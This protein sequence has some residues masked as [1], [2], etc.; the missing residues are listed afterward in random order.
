MGSAA[1]SSEIAEQLE[2]IDS[3]CTT[4][5]RHGIDYWLFGGRAV[6]FGSGRS[7]RAHD[8]IDIAAWRVDYDAIIASLLEAGWHHTPVPDE[9]VGTRYEW[10]GTVQ[11]EFTFVVADDT[12]A[13]V[14]P[15]PEQAV[16]WSPRPFGETRR[17]VLRCGRP[18]TA[19]CPA[20]GR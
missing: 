3:V 9:V 12:G 2:A 11:V 15:S 4:L 19:V 17:A 6:D 13:V 14:V 10:D 16:I 8:D 7:P 18:N 5:D 1:E 20:Q